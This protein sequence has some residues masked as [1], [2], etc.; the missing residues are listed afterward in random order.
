MKN[1]VLETF[2][3][4]GRH[5]KVTPKKIAFIFLSTLTLMMNGVMHGVAHSVLFDL[6]EFT[7]VDYSFENLYVK[8]LFQ[9]KTS[10]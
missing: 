5:C 3:E 1:E 4:F 2:I 6:N 8:Y 10:L 7:L 9:M